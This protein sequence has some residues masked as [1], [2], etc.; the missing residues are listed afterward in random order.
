MHSSL[1]PASSLQIK[2]QDRHQMCIELYQEQRRQEMPEELQPRMSFKRTR[3]TW[4][5]SGSVSP[6]GQYTVGESKKQCEVLSTGLGRGAKSKQGVARDPHCTVPA[7]ASPV[8]QHS[9]STTSYIPL[10]SSGFKIPPFREMQKAKWKLNE[11]KHAKL[12]QSW[13]GLPLQA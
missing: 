5:N 1:D 6:G 12:L 13:L 10:L 7:L 4:K 3:A 8:L 2:A 9:S 11:G